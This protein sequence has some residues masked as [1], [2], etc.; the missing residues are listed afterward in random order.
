TAVVRWSYS[1]CTAVIQRLYSGCTAGTRTMNP[2]YNPTVYVES[3]ETL[4]GTKAT[5]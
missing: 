2:C 3:S 5:A 1:G 4:C